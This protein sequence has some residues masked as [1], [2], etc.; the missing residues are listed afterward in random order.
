M[1]AQMNDNYPIN[2]AL[3]LDHQNVLIGDYPRVLDFQDLNLTYQGEIRI[4]DSELVE[5]IHLPAFT[6]IDVVIEN[7]PNLK[8]IHADEYGPTWLVCRNLPKLKTITVDGSLR[9]LSV[10]G[11]AQLQIIDVG[12]CEH[13]GYLSVR[14]APK[15]DHVNVEQCRLLPNIE[16][17]S[18]ELQIQLG[19]TQQI[20]AIQSRSK[21]NSIR[22]EGMT[23]TDIDLVLA[24][25]GHGEVLLKRRFLESMGESNIAD[26]PPREY[27]YRLLDPG[28]D[29]YTGGTGEAYCYAFDVATQGTEQDEDEEFID[30][31]V[32]IH[33]PED[34]IEEALSWVNQGS[35]I[36]LRDGLPTDDQVLSFINLLLVDPNADLPSW[37]YSK[38]P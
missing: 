15:L 28:E 19:V 1:A 33:E 4:S 11:A 16:G 3:A 30:H 14:N 36:P 20:E 9:W 17:L 21:R 29:V 18:A 6:F 24:N 35:K 31:E 22:Y 23:F 2:H 38:Q 8:E 37:I 12:K 25:I 34:A 10:D 7:L 32:G 27:S 26:M 13:L 5:S